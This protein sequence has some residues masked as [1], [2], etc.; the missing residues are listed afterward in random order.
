MEFTDRQILITRV[1]S[2]KM[3]GAAAV[4][5]LL[6]CVTIL[7]GV[8]LTFT[9]L[10]S[11]RPAMQFAALTFLPLLLA[12]IRA[13]LRV[14]AAQEMLPQIKSQIQQQSWIHLVLGV[15]IPYLYLANFAASAFGRRIRWRGISYEL[16]SPQ[17]TRIL[18][19]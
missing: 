8:I 4:T 7:T 12:A 5:H 15:F 2:P 16:V 19:R 11:G 3:W 13:A 18:I 6:F 14:T 9:H 17:Q 1:Y 10:I